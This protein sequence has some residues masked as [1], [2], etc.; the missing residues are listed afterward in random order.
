MFADVQDRFDWDITATDQGHFKQQMMAFL[1][2]TGVVSGTGNA[3]SFASVTSWKQEPFWFE[4]SQPEES[5]RS[6][7]TKDVGA[8][9]RPS[10]TK[11]CLTQL[12][13]AGTCSTSNGCL[14]VY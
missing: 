5:W 14:M 3:R 4:R 2:K 8:K 9:P 7:W 13:L 11:P 1:F 12:D 6:L 10:F